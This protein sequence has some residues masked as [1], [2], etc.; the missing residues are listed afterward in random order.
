MTSEE[1]EDKA[2]H[3]HKKYVDEE[4][5]LKMRFLSARESCI[6]SA[7]MRMYGRLKT[8]YHI[9]YMQSLRSR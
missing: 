7:R 9:L 4:L 2:D 6:A 1:L 3:Y 8:M 5:K